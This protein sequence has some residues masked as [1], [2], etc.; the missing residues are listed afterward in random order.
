VVDNL[1]GQPEA[2]AASIRPG[3]VTKLVAVDREG[4]TVYERP[5]DLGG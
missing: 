4:A 5:L 2:E 1:F 3:A